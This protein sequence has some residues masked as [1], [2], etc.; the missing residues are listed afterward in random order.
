[1]A[2]G[3]KEDL[4]GKPFVGRSGK[5][6]DEI[7]SFAGLNPQEDV[8]ITNILKCRPPKNRD[9]SS[10]EQDLCMKHLNR[11]ISLIAPK[12]LVCVGR[13]AACR[14]IDKNFKIMKSHGELFKVGEQRVTA[15]LHPA[16]ILRNMNN[17]PYAHEDWKKVKEWSEIL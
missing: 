1:E 14:I 7:L 3:E 12:L 6:L 15:V 11:Q 9:P 17:L 2:P 16:A 8:Y 4:E 13:V 10:L 5:L